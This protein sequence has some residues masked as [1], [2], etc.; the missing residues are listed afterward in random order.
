MLVFDRIITFLFIRTTKI[1]KK[2]SN[3]NFLISFF[4]TIFAYQKMETMTPKL[5]T[6]VLPLLKSTFDFNR[7]RAKGEHNEANFY[8]A[9]L[10]LKLL[11]IPQLDDLF[12]N[13]IGFLL[14]HFPVSMFHPPSFSIFSFFHCSI[15]GVVFFSMFL[16]TV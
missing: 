12:Q 8:A 2:F 14:L 6:K 9:Y 16:C 4:I 5:L 7:A 15:F 1:T 10:V 3:K 13:F 11:D